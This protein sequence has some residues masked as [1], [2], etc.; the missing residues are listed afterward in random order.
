MQEKKEKYTIRQLAAICRMTVKE[1][2]E[3][4]NIDY[5]HLQ[6]VAQ[7]KATMTGADMIRLWDTTGIDPHM[8]EI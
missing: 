4:S 1:L 3:K 8:F 7:K 5:Y 2:A 6:N